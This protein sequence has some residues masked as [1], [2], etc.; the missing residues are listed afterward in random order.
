MTILMRLPAITLLLCASLM[1]ADGSPPTP[2]GFRGDGS[3]RYPNANP[4]LEWARVAK[5][6]QEL[7]AQA[8]KPKDDA[9]PGKEAAIPDGVIR[10]WLIL[11]PVPITKEQKLEE[12]VPN[13]ETLTP[14]DKEK[15]GELA[16]NSVSVDSSCVDLCSI[17]NVAPEKAGFAAFA[18]TYIYSPS[19][20]PVRFNHMFQG[21]G[22][23]RIWLNGTALYTG[24]KN[25]DIHSEWPMTLA[26][27]KGWN[28]LLLMNAKTLDTRK[29]F[30]FSGSLHGDKEPQYDNHGIVWRTPLPISGSSA[31]VIMGDRIFL[32]ME[33]GAVGCANKSDGKPL[34]FRSLTFLD[35]ATDEERKANPE[36]FAALAVQGAKLKKQDES[37]LAVPWK[38]PA[39]EADF[40][41]SSELPIYKEM[42]KVSRDKYTNGMNGCEVDFTAC[43]PITDGQCV[44]A[45]FGNGIVACYDKDGNCKWKQ[46]LKHRNVEHGYTTSPLLVDGRLVC[47]LDNFTELDAKT[48]ATV[49]ERPHFLPPGKAF[50]W[51]THFHGSGVV[52]D[53]GGEKV[54]YFPN[55]EFV[56]FSDGKT[57][58]IDDKTLAVLGPQGWTGAG[59]RVTTP[60]V[61][62]KVCYKMGPNG[63]VA[64]K[65]R[66]LKGDQVDVEVL[67]DVP[68]NTNKFPFYY[69]ACNCASPLLHQGLLYVINDFGTLSVIDMEKGDVAY[70]KQLDIE[71][72]MPYSVPDNRLK[73]GVS[74]SP[75]LA[76]NRIF[77][78]GNQ[79]TSI[80]FEP[81][82]TFKQ[83][84][85]MRLENQPENQAPW[86]FAHQ[87]VTM[88]E[89]VFEGERM[90]Y[91]SENALFCVGQK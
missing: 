35:F 27:K 54:L 24:P 28:R 9:A 43:A 85:R 14:D 37:D 80:A 50:N 23:N 13:I 34:W 47:Y 2:M 88:T 44:Y 76:G 72:F 78:F 46:L 36:V 62:N 3:G 38:M 70:Q 87:D 4:P 74:A 61:D 33:F 5:S 8:R 18:L 39:L 79:G 40:R 11:G 65:L 75:T 71:I 45:M 73:G 59:D 81:G 42:A 69:G 32:T 53:A 25:S 58:A 30:W 68:F 21:Q 60:V 22:H 31:P 51:Y 17:L 15:W 12:Y 86:S 49:V 90:Y 20:T 67:K 6:V 52:L 82:R 56:R 89:P 64:F 83:V 66:P 41:A 48:G 1:A 19:G 63:A 10:Q 7:S 57:L 77:I 91:R 84:A 55:G 16:W 29:T 26:L